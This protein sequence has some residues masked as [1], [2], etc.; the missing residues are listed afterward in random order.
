MELS[1]AELS[2]AGAAASDEFTYQDSSFC[3]CNTKSN[4]TLCLWC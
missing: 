1:D 4:C 2:G 3:K